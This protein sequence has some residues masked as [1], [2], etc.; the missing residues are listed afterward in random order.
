MKNDQVIK[1]EEVFNKL[2]VLAV[3]E[4]DIGRVAYFGETK[5]ARDFFKLK[6]N[7]KYSDIIK[8]LENQEQS[9][10]YI[11]RWQQVMKKN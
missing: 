2:L 6:E 1:F 5:D 9:N 7:D 10:Y 3:D 11:N 8:I 4:K